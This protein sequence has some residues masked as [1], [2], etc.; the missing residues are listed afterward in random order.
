MKKRLSYLQ[1]YTADY[2]SDPKLRMCSIAARGLWIEM[3][4]IMHEA[5][6]YGHLVIGGASPTD[7][8]LGLVAAVPPETVSELLAEL[9]ARGVFSRTRKGV[10]FSKRLV[11]MAKNRE[12]SVKFGKRGGN[13]SLRK[14]KEKAEGVN[15]PL[16]QGDK[17]RGLEVR[18]LEV[19]EENSLSRESSS[20]GQA[21]DSAQDRKIEDQPKD[22]PLLRERMLAAMGLDPVSGMDACGRLR[23]TGADMDRVKRWM[24][25]GLTADECVQVAAEGKAK[26]K[27]APSFTYLEKIAIQ[28]LE[29][30]KSPIAINRNGQSTETSEQR[31]NRWKLMIGGGE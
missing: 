19:K 21:R 3:I 17:L 25:L 23:G 24:E 29:D 12:N 11:N 2:R 16:N 8:E 14:Q 9:E 6:P 20:S 5:D 4:C 10:I 30:R 22:E 18:G 27:S 26:A 1:F 7:H 13:P 31:R 15:P 28:R